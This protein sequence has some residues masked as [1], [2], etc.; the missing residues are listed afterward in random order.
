M[1]NN[2]FGFSESPFSITPDPRFFYTNP[3]YQEAYA[4]LR[5]GIEKKRGFIVI[6]GEVGTGKSTLLRK[7]MRNLGDTIHAAFIFNP[8][9]TFP[10]LLRVTLQDLG[11]SPD[12][13]CKVSMLQGLNDYLIKQLE[14]GHIVSVLIDEAQ[15]LS[16]EALE[17][18][19]LLSNLETD[20]EKLLQIVLMGQPE[21]ERKLD[22]PTLRQLKQ[23]VAVQ[24]RL[25]PLQEK[26]VGPYIDFRL[27]AVGYEGKTL[28]RRDAVQEIAFY[29]KGIPRLM[30][31][32]CDN[33]L[34]NAYA[35]SQGTVSA[36]IIRE[37]ARDLRLG[38]EVQTHEAGTTPSVIVSN[39]APEPF[40]SKA[41][42][43]VPQHK[44][45]R[46]AKVGIETSLLIFVFLALASTID[47]RNIGTIAGR[48]L[49][50][51]K[52]NL[53][54]WVVFV[55]QQATIPKKVN[56]EVEF[57][58]KEQRVVIPQGS[59]IYK[60]VTDTYRANAA[61]GMDLIKEFN[62][63]I[64]NLNKISAG[65]DLLLPSLTR[66]TLLRKQPDGSYRLI[67]GSFQNLRA[68]NEYARLLN[69]KGHQVTITSRKISNSLLVHRVEIDGLKNL[70]EANQ[71]W[72]TGVRNEWITLAGNPVSTGTRE[73]D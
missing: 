46:I 63:E 59:S 32:I 60:I 48:G 24:C 27:R 73:I 16:A 70:E 49:E 37:V 4:N 7:L 72:E 29:S 71:I 35:G 1:Y 26:E 17:G 11:L 30:N 15:N 9:L 61:L 44:M 28:F 18:L 57:K 68:A 47:P 2:Y 22:Q 34:L 51:A 69:S 58:R 14:Q 43:D 38:P 33:A 21:L 25:E 8:D 39:A 66:E 12:E 20:Q 19:R 23:R 53:N 6:T 5:Y 62:P 45:R 10:E 54:Q 36:D 31:I 50:V 40:L 41:A 67:V 13:T 3:V 55:T 56:A 65:Q 52:H 64:K 42:N